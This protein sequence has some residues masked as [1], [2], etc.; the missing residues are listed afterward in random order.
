MAKNLLVAVGNNGR[1]YR[2]KEELPVDVGNVQFW[3]GD[4]TMNG[5]SGVTV[6]V[7]SLA[8]KT[9]LRKEGEVVLTGIN[10]LKMPSGY[11]ISDMDGTTGLLARSSS[12]MRVL[13][14]GR[15]GGERNLRSYNDAL[16]QVAHRTITRK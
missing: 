10:L 6:K 15:I 11:Q 2:T 14:N 13:R 12:S 5:L 7:K 16:R 9:A 3:G 8:G 4:A 1:I